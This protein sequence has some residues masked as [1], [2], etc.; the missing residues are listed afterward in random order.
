M[1]KLLLV[2]TLLV[3]SLA[4]QSQNT[5]DKTFSIKGTVKNTI[6]GKVYL[7]R[8]NDRNIAQ[9]IDSVALGAGNSFAFKGKMQE[10]GIYQI[11][12]A[13][14]QTIGLILDG[15]ENITVTAEGG[16]TPDKPGTFNVEGSA[17]MAKFNQ[18]LAEG[19]NFNKSILALQTQFDAAETKKDEKKK[20]E[21]QTAYQNAYEVHRAKIKPMIGELGTSLA[22]ILAANNFLNPE[23][24]YEFMEQLA[25]KLEAEGQKH[26]FARLF[27]QQIN[28][29]KAG[30]VGSQAPDFQLIDLAGKTVKLSDYRGKTVIIDFWATWC[31]PCIMSFPG[32]KLAMDKYKDNPNVV[33]LFVDTYERVAPE[34]I[35]THV[36]GFVKQRGFTD[37]HVLLD[38]AGEIATS[39]GVEGIPAKF[40]IDKDGKVKYKSTGYL[41]SAQKILDEMTH[42][43][44]N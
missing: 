25:Q 20:K 41:G 5:T 42:W 10:P 34:Q 38:V 9:K 22:G 2:T 35:P 21:L 3:G 37:Y 18:I 31:G 17:T 29:K 43:V 7:E 23:L 32:M 12:I 1:K 40:C 24:D 27:I 44:E 15:N 4:C 28:R 14:Q 30:T 26:Y 39:Y 6:T 33:F 13:D 11:N 19:Q 8:M 36:A 16:G